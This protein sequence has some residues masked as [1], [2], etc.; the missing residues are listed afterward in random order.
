MTEQDYIAKGRGKWSEKGVPKKGW[1]CTDIEDLGEPS[2]TCEMCESQHI[3]YVHYMENERYENI[4]SVGCVCAG[5]MEHDLAASKHR[6]QSMK[7]RA[8]KRKR[9]VNRKAWKTSQKGNTYIEADGYRVIVRQVKGRWGVSI[10]K[11]GS[12]SVVHS[13]RTV[14]NMA[15]AK[16]AGFDFVTK[17]LVEKR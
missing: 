8:G 15:N 16:L 7:S 2:I 10:A 1:V 3:R 5:N 17:K 6:E 9:W 13:R 14:K 12:E 4:L 11:I